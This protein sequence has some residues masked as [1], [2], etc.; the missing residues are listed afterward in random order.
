MTSEPCESSVVPSTAEGT[1]EQITHVVHLFYSHV[2]DDP[3]IGP[4]FAQ[5]VRDWDLHL[6]E[7]RNFWSTH[8]LG[9]GTYR[10][11]GFGHHMRLPLEEAHFVRWLELWEQAANEALTP[12]LAQRAV[13]K[14]RHM[15]N[16]FKTGLL[17]YKRPDGS[18]SRTP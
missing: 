6:A 7:M 11:N 10:G 14:A 15:A 5:F 12:P 4:I 8:L 9:I 16:S 1:D 3:L 17:P 18:S 2:Y 13:A